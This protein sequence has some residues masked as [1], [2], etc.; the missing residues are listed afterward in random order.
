MCNVMEKCLWYIVKWKNLRGF[1]I[2]GN[3]NYK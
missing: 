3:V 1:D 2:L